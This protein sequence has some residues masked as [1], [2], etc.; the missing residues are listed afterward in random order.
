[1]STWCQP[2]VKLES[3]CGTSTKTSSMSSWRAVAG[4]RKRH[5][6][7]QSTWRVDLITHRLSVITKIRSPN[8]KRKRK[9]LKSCFPS[10]SNLP[11]DLWVG[12]NVA[13]WQQWAGAGYRV[14][15][16]DWK[17]LVSSACGRSLLFLRVLL[18]Y[19][20]WSAEGITVLMIPGN[21]VSSLAGLSVSPRLIPT[22]L[23]PS[24]SRS[25]LAT[26]YARHIARQRL[27]TSL[28]RLGATTGQG[29]STSLHL[30]GA[31]VGRRLSTGLHSLAAIAG[32]GLSTSLHSLG[33]IAGQGLSTDLGRVVNWFTLPW[34]NSYQWV[35]ARHSS[36][37]E[38]RMHLGT[39]KPRVSQAG[40][41]S[42]QNTTT[43]SK[44]GDGS[45]KTHGQSRTA[46]N[47]LLMCEYHQANIAIPNR[48][49]CT[50]A[51]LLGLLRGHVL[52]QNC[53]NVQAHR[54]KGQDY[55]RI[56]ANGKCKSRRRSHYRHA[57]NLNRNRRR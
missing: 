40:F 7:C 8:L 31:I 37:T 5:L 38:P 52:D 34:S 3:S 12:K 56:T 14:Q 55:S 45:S 41:K 57:L 43:E 9:E 36:G 42:A 6:W 35:L 44:G 50:Q 48:P 1:M 25:G 15:P 21:Q 28:Y 20:S 13:L 24:A 53:P 27:S 17:Y 49:Y 22:S 29:L 10:A 4:F 11:S 16:G 33:A 47:S 54:K 18:D 39:A 51:C 30:L 19:F 26:F 32:Q 23:L 46:A 2:D